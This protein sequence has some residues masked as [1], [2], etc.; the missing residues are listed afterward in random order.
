M[1]SRLL[2]AALA[3]VI[4]TAASSSAAQITFAFTGTVSTVGSGLGYFQSGDVIVGTYTFESTTAPRAGGTVD[5]N[6]WDALIALTVSVSRSG[7]DIYSVSTTGAPEIQ[8][9]NDLGFPF[10]DRYFL[11]ARASDGLASAT[12]IPDATLVSFGMLLTDSSE[13]V[14]TDALTLPPTLSLASF[15][16]RGFGL[17]FEVPAT[18]GTGV[19]ASAINGQ[20]TSLR[21]VNAAEV[22]EPTT[23]LLLGTGVVASRARRLLKKRG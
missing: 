2:L 13:T 17:D 14:F 9:E 15:D 4:L 11:L 20:I 3:I 10:F 16:G 21:I 18:G 6:V 1:R 19:E 8:I 12:V 23:L 7:S 5:S 22:P